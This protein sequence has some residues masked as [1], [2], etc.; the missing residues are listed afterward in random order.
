M[1]KTDRPVVAER[2]VIVKKTLQWILPLAGGAVL[3]A[4]A[5][6]FLT[7]PGRVDNNRKEAFTGRNYA[8]RGLHGKRERRPENSLPAFQAAAEKGYGIELDVRLTADGRLAV[9]P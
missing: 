2:D 6:V 4:A 1:E 9:T 8:H 7:A 3:T 5:A